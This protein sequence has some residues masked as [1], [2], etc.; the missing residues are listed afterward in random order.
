MLADSHAPIGAEGKKRHFRGQMEQK[1]GKCV[2]KKESQTDIWFP[3]SVS[4]KM[5][6]AL[7]G[8]IAAADAMPFLDDRLGGTSGLHFEKFSW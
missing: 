5:R 2:F 3:R 1:I 8:V 7:Y 6:G 4:S